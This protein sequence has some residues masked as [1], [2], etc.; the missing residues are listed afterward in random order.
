MSLRR[1]SVSGGLV[2]AATRSRSAGH[3][4]EPRAL[5]SCVFSGEDIVYYF[6]QYV[7]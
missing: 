6:E 4:A 3:T 5:A 1:P 2:A 7:L